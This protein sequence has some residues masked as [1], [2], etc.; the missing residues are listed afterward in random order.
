MIESENTNVYSL[1]VNHH[2]VNQQLR[3]V[4]IDSEAI[5]L[6]VSSILRQ[7]S[8]FGYKPDAKSD[9]ITPYTEENCEYLY[10]IVAPSIS[11]V[12]SILL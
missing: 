9:R 8:M 4:L 12:F 2:P 6:S 1:E 5:V 7:V 10:I 3:C 11:C